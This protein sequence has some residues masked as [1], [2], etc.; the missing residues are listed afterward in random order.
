M[1]KNLISIEHLTW[2]YQ[3]NTSP[4]FRDFNFQFDQGQF[5][6]LSWKSGTGKSSLVKLLLW[7][8]DAPAKSIYYKGDDIMKFSVKEAQAYRK[9]IGVVF[10]DYKL[11]DRMTVKANILY[12]LRLSDYTTSMIDAK[13]NTIVD[14]LDLHLLSDTPVKF[15]S[16]GHQQKVAIARAL[17]TDPEIIIV[18]EPTWNLDW[19]DTK[20][21]A[22]ILLDLHKTW[23]A[24]LFISHDLHLIEYM[25]L[26]GTISVVTL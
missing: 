11:L 9:N 1:T 2:G 20:R 14:V 18:D 22:D 16:G 12:P 23:V 19:E 15:L 8:E 13:Y 10:Q 7:Q 4:V 3:N 21:I 6:V 26:K 25:K 24:I 17:I 5:V